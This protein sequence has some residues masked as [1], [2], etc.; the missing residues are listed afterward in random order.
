MLLLLLV[1]FSILLLSTIS[2][3]IEQ[4][5]TILQNNDENKLTA[6]QSQYIEPS[7]NIQYVYMSDYENYRLYK[8][9]PRSSSTVTQTAIANKWLDQY[10]K[11]SFETPDRSYPY[12]V[13]YCGSNM[14]AFFLRNTTVSI[15]N[16]NA[17]LM[18][19]LEAYDNSQYVCYLSVLKEHRQHGLGTKL[20][21]VFINEAIRTN[22]ARVSLHVNTENKSALS[23]YL[24]CGMRCTD[25]ISGY[26][27]GDRTY[28]TQNAFTMTLQ[29]KNVQNSTA[30]CQS[31]TAVNI[32][33]QEDAVYKQRCPQALAG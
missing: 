29:L 26:Y 15:Q 24:K 12:V 28:P 30:V 13:Q 14:L 10:L 32:P 27:F 2:I 8:L 9:I 4:A 23:L 16:I 18:S 7:T 3:P 25:Y 6:K 11:L 17:L 20:L 21:N 31:T 33:Q 19:R 1:Q 22:N 5:E